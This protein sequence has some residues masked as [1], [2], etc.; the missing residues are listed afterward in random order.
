MNNWDADI[1]GNIVPIEE[2]YKNN[3]EA[4]FL[5]LKKDITAF[6][7]EELHPYFKYENDSE[8]AENADGRT[9]KVIADDKLLLMQE[10]LRKG[11]YF[12]AYTRGWEM[13]KRLNIF[14]ELIHEQLDEEISLIPIYEQVTEMF[15]QFLLNHSVSSAAIINQVCAENI[16][17]SSSVDKYLEQAG[18][19]SYKS[20]SFWEF[21]LF[22][23]CMIIMEELY[24][25]KCEFCGNLFAYN[26]EREIMNCNSQSCMKS[27]SNSIYRKAYKTYHARKK[28]DNM[29]PEA[30]DRWVAYAKAM[31]KNFESNRISQVDYIINIRNVDK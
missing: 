4:Y 21:L 27:A 2:F 24:V 25:G 22:E 7:K 29:T 10:L 6:P 16:P 20:R 12:L 18:S 14:D 1:N 3:H 11:T 13:Y 15:Y 8:S 9:S 19:Y 17:W 23:L 26:E 28:N 5:F 31:K 30:F